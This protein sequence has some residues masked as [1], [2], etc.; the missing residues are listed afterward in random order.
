MKVKI[1]YHDN[2]NELKVEVIEV[3]E[4]DEKD[5]KFNGKRGKYM[6][7]MLRK[8]LNKDIVAFSIL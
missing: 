7:E 4:I 1:F 2:K 5:I 8:K 3:T 6:L